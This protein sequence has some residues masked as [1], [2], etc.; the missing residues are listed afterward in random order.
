[1]VAAKQAARVLANVERMV[2]IELLSAAQALELRGV[3][4]A[5]VGTRAAYE[6][7]RGRVPPLAED[8]PLGQDVDTLCNMITEGV[9]EIA[10]NSL[11]NA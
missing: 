10:V 1:M 11:R 8:R 6:T 7:I 4:G 2:A 9:L 5:G 3:A